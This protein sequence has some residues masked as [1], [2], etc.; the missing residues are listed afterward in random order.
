MDSAGVYSTNGKGCGHNKTCS[1]T[2]PVRGICPEGWHLPNRN[3]WKSFY[4]AIGS[5][6]YAMQAKIY[7]G[8]K[9]A[10]DAYGFSASPAGLYS[11]GG[12]SYVGTSTY[13]WSSTEDNQYRALYW[14]LTT[15]EA[16]IYSLFGDTGKPYGKSVRC[17]KD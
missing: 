17:I 14:Y 7:A 16:Y 2:E 6:P 11:G 4:S 10:T 5:S 12:F 1:T 3:E 15:K 9:G 8:W 13:F